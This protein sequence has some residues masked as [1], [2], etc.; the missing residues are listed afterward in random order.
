MKE[1]EL[2]DITFGQWQSMCNTKDCSDC[3][4]A[5]ACVLLF[6][7]KHKPWEDHLLDYKVDW[8]EDDL[9]KDI[10][11]TLKTAKV[12][13][14]RAPYWLILDPVQNMSCDCHALA[15]QITGPFFCRDDAEN[16]LKTRR[17]AF[18]KRAVVYCLSGYESEKW[19]NL[20]KNIEN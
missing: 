5:E 18:S 16:H 19:D 8:A 12:E 1:V 10:I 15:N 11:K 3:E 13:C 2:K 20:W 7:L 4:Y 14:T 17:Y 6:G 9:M